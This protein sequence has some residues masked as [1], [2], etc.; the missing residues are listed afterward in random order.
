MKQEKP[1]NPKTKIP[2]EI[3]EQA[4][5]IISEFNAATFKKN[6][7]IEYYAVYRTGFLY[8]N[9]REGERDGPVARLRYKGSIDT[10]EFAIFKWS[11]ERYDPDEIFFPGRNQLNGTIEGAL[12]A[13]NEAYPPDYNPPPKELFDFIRNLFS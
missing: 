9:R 2:E 1:Q 4:N 11:S 6:S 3:K 13:G 10:W 8:L 5:K 7:G 12:K